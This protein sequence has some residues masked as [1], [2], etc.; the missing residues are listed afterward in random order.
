[1]RFG[2]VDIDRSTLERTVRPSAR[3]L[4]EIARTGRLGSVPAANR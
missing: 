1:M 4:G 3:F 2:L